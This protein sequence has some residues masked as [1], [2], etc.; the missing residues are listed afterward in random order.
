MFNDSC[1]CWII[2]DKKPCEYFKRYVLPLE[3]SLN[4]QYNKIDNSVDIVDLRR[5]KCGNV[6]EKHRRFCDKCN[7]KNK[8]ETKRKNWHKRRD[9]SV[10][11]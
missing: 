6:L 8:L 1:E 7:K 5:C 10:K 11:D 2:K 3:P 9:I 4:S